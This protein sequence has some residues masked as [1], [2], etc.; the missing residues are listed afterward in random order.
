VLS[1]LGS[2]GK[3]GFRDEVGGVTN[4][5]AEDEGGVGASRDVSVL[6]DAGEC[7]E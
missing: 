6:T 5:S 2:S 3:E 1:E 4:D 7:V